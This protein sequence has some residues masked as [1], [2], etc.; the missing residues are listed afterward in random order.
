[1][2]LYSYTREL[3]QS[4]GLRPRKRLGQTFLVDTRVLDAI[5]EAAE[6]SPDDV[7]LEI[8]AGTG[9]LTQRLALSPASIIAVEL[10][11]GL[12]RILQSIY[13]DKSNVNVI[14]A[15]ILKLDF[16]TLQSLCAQRSSIKV[17]G[18]LPYYITKPILMKVLDESSRLPIQMFLAMVQREVGARMA[19]SPGTK[20]Y[21]AL[22]IAIAYRSDVEILKHVSAASFYPKPGVDSTLVKLNIRSKP[23]VSVRD[24]WLFFYIVRAA[25]QYRR[26]ILRNALLLAGRS[27]EIQRKGIKLDANTVDSALQSLMIDPG[28]RGETLG[29]AEFADLANM[30]AL[31]E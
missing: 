20:D 19:A 24:E 18:N 23:S 8:G 29:I 6:L 5:V 21:G 26:K 10:D 31:D 12:F 17:I 3:L 4:A 22:S 25:F 30:L 2:S 28:R 9:A 14:H 1:M 27:D 16:L 15:D 13:Q 7:I 11:N